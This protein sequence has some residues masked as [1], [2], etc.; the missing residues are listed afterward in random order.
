MRNLNKKYVCI[1]QHDNKDCAVACID[2]VSKHYGL[3]IPISKIRNLA[4]TDKHG[5]SFY[6]IIKAL[7]Q[8]GFSAKGFKAINKKDISSDIHL[9]AI[10]HILH[11]NKTFHY[12]VIHEITEKTVIIADPASGIVKLKS[13]EFLDIW[14]GNLIL[15]IPLNLFEKANITKSTSKK[16]IS[17]ILSQKILLFKIFLVSITLTLLGIIGTFYFKVILDNVIPNNSFKTLFLVSIAIITVSVFKV[18]SEALRT[19]LLLY[20]GQ[21]INLHLMLGYYNHVVNLPMDFFDKRETG[22]IISRFNDASKIREAISGA[23]LTIILDGLMVV[24]GSII[25]FTTNQLLFIVTILPIILYIIIVFTFKNPIEAV[26]VETMQ[27]DAEL[28][29]YLVESFSGIELIKTF[30]AELTAQQEMEKRFRKLLRSI[31]KSGHIIN[32]HNSLKNSIQIL[33]PIII[34]WVGTIEVLKGN[35]SIGQLLMYNALLAYFLDPLQRIINLQST[36][37]SAIVAADRLYEI[38]DLEVENSMGKIIPSSLKGSIEFKNITYRYGTRELILNDIS[39]KINSGEKVALIGES[40]AGKT[41]LVK[42]LINFYQ[43]ENGEILINGCNVNDISSEVLRSKIG[44]ISQNTFFF[45]GTI[46]ENLKFADD[47]I[48]F[49]EI[50]A[51]CK[52]AQIHDFI[53]SLPLGYDTFLEENASNLSG[54]QKQRLAIARVLLKKPEILIMDEATSNLDS[55][56]EKAIERTIKEATEGITSIIIAHRLSTVMSC[57]TIYVME[58][59]AIIEKGNHTILIKNKKG[60]YHNLWNKQFSAGTTNTY[61]H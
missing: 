40:G 31:I 24:I 54:G 42:L 16:F 25:L 57:N 22:E 30:N 15:I 11:N 4:G 13:E 56:T 3:N 41:T 18:I 29:S 28:T 38:L 34:L 50:V 14:T 23:A 19:H 12:V 26:N 45:R 53:V 2:I 1:N 17:L 60:Y 21:N 32:I 43:C 61:I 5:T 52:K 7:E 33:S 35:L 51:S 48:T 44:Y 59:G 10:A 6:G 20:L 47:N 9:P 36:I 58:K 8:L 39:L 49:D 46:E 27:D 55:I 37:Q